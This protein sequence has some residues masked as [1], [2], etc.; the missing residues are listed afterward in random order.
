MPLIRQLITFLLLLLAIATAENYTQPLHRTSDLLLASPDGQATLHASSAPSGAE[1]LSLTLSG[2]GC[3]SGSAYTAVHN[4]SLDVYTPR[5][6][7]MSGPDQT[8]VMDGRRFC[9]LVLDVKVPVAWQMGLKMAESIGYVSLGED[10]E[11]QV[12]GTSYFAGDE[13]QVHESPVIESRKGFADRSRIRG[14]TN[15][16]G[17]CTIG[18][19]AGL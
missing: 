19:R 13:A 17:R 8:G 1:L 12:V 5:L 2:S 3:P 6:I 11:G 7:V 4:A 14:R 18:G 9:Q 15:W 16:S 10:V